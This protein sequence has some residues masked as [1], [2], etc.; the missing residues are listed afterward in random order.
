MPNEEADHGFSYVWVYFR[1]SFVLTMKAIKK[2]VIQSEKYTSREVTFR[3]KTAQLSGTLTSPSDEDADSKT[4]YP[5]VLLIWGAGP[6][7]RNYQGFFESAADYLSK[8]GYCV[9]RFDKNG[10]GSS[11]GN[12]SST[13]R[14]DEFD[15]V[16]AALNF[17]KSQKT[18]NINRISVIAHSEGA[19][20]A[21]RLAAENPDIKGVVLM[22]PLIYLEPHDAEAALRSRAA[23][24]KWDD[25]Y[26]KLA[27][28]AAQETNDRANQT[29]RDWGYILGKRCYLKGV[30][31]ENTVMPKE[32]IG[33]VLAPI[34]I[35]H[36]KNDSEV[37]VEHAAH[38]DKTLSDYGTM[39]HSV[40]YFSY[41]GH[42]FGK[43]VNDGSLKRY[44]DIDKEALVS[45]K[46][47]LGLNTAEP[48]KQEAAA[49]PAVKP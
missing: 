13:T 45:I 5:A 8:S 34:L 15:S 22:A 36:G 23:R 27:L 19:F 2:R 28:R 32:T 37:P 44:Y 3:G 31:I 7:D 43:L 4:A 26:L 10:I 41:L 39:R 11:D 16:C 21:V 40:T 42:F 6:Q 24:E 18:I 30:R 46:D 17:L 12:A 35:L 14:D 49:A 47:W 33:K 48:V 1:G 38:M 20:N 29:K 25:E 9:L